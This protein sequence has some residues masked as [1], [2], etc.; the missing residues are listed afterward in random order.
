MDEQ[1]IKKDEC[2]YR[3][4]AVTKVKGNLVLTHSKLCFY[5]K[6]LLGGESLIIEIPIKSIVSTNAKKAFGYGIEHLIVLYKTDKKEERVTFE[7]I[8]VASWVG[9]GLSRLE[10]LWF[11]EWV[12]LIDDLRFGKMSQNRSSVDDLE[13]LAKLKEKGIITEEEFKKKKS[14]LLEL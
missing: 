3:K 5:K 12:K 8:S 4:S 7:K 6:K 9:G 14:K 1:I 10:N 11:S 2:L 13:K